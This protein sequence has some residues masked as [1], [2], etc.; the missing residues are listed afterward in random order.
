L[1][2]GNGLAREGV[3]LDFVV[4]RFLIVELDGKTH[5]E[6]RAIKKDRRR[7]NTSVAGGFTVLKLRPAPP[8]LSPQHVV[9]SE[10][11]FPSTK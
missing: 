6:P 9:P 2:C 8:N 7:D 11:A 10:G 1:A 5:F 3:V 4:E